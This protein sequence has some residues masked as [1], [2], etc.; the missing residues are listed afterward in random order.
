MWFSLPFILVRCIRCNSVGFSS[1]LDSFNV[2]LC[3]S[4]LLVFE[5]DLFCGGL[6]RLIQCNSVGFSPELDSF[7]IILWGSIFPVFELDL[8]C[9]VQSDSFNVIL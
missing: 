9:G 6:V 3:G 2:I 5:L 1:E 8:L 7:N 4:V